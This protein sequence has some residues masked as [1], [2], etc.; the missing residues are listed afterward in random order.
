MWE[1]L[2][3]F[4]V[5]F[6][7]VDIASANVCSHELLAFIWI[8]VNSPNCFYGIGINYICMYV[9][10]CTLNAVNIFNVGTF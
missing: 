7:G 6:V 5:W 3:V 1:F 4:L 9:C 8:C 2:A 10:I